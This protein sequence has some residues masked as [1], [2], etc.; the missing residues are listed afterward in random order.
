[1]KKMRRK[2]TRRLDGQPRPHTPAH[3]P[4]LHEIHDCFSNIETALQRI[5]RAVSRLKAEAALERVERALS[6]A[7]LVPNAEP[8]G[9]RV[10]VRP[11]LVLDR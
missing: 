9:E 4:E 3:R 6:E 11:A 1:M 2:H 7:P 8:M 5:E 10:P